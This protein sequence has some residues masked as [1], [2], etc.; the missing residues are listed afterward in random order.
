MK[1]AVYQKCPAIGGKVKSANIDTVKAMAGVKDVFVL[2]GN[3][4]AMELLPGVAIVAD[5]T[6]AAIRAKR[7]LKVEWDESDAATDSWSQVAIEAEQLR[8]QTG[9]QVVNTGDVDAAFAAGTKQVSGF[10][11][12]HFVS[13]AQLEPQNCTASFNDGALELWAPTQMPGR[14]IASAATVVGI[15]P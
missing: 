7:A 8:H 9:P 2:G 4:N 6:W 13:H 1:Y 14:G 11:R 15:P 12:Y 3:G 10:Y 5:S